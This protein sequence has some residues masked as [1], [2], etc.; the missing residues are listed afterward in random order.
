MQLTEF[1]APSTTIIIKELGSINAYNPCKSGVGVPA[2]PVV[3][4]NE[5]KRNEKCV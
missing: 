1:D 4:L 2:E 3:E 5:V